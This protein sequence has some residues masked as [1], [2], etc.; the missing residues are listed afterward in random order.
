MAGIGPIV[1]EPFYALSSLIH[2][3]ET[4]AKALEQA[5]TGQA[6]WFDNFTHRYF[7]RGDDKYASAP[8]FDD[9]IAGGNSDGP[10]SAVR[11]DEGSDGH[12]HRR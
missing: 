10:R 1:A 8:S 7:E 6:K 12:A 3:A 2:V 11:V 4:D 9:L 5:R